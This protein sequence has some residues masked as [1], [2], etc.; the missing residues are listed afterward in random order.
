MVLFLIATS[1]KKTK[2]TINFHEDYFPL[3]DNRFVEYDVTRISHDH[4]AG[5]HET[6]NYVLKT[7]IRDTVIDNSGRIA[8]KFYRYIFDNIFQEYKVKD[9][10]TA[11][12]D[13]YRAELVEEN[14]RI[15]KLVFAPTLGKE[16]DI[17]AFNS[18]DPLLAYYENIHKPLTVNNYHFDSTV[19]V[20][21]EKMDPN[22]VEYRRKIEVYAKNIGLVYKFYKDLTIKDFDTLQPQKG[23]ELYYSIKNYGIE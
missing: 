17:N 21:Q 2:T 23:E 13:E 12:I 7:I 18:K 22:L 10:W 1:C 4:V 8:K 15:V 9:L 14:E 6:T 5:K 20:V 19:T 11:I 16:W 3:E